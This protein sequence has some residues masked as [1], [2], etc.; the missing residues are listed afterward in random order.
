M[1]VFLSF[2]LKVYFCLGAH[3]QQ[4]TFA[5]YWSYW[6]SP[7]GLA[8]TSRIVLLPVLVTRGRS[9]RKCKK[10]F[11]VPPLCVVFFFFFFFP[12]LFFPSFLCT[13]KISLWI[14][15]FWSLFKDFNYCVKSVAGQFLKTLGFVC[16]SR[17]F[18][19][20]GFLLFVEDKLALDILLLNK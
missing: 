3:F 1:W 14:E 9:K 17:C 11:L 16:M 4:S 18:I 2:N 13:W 12:L 20:S 19:V 6:G 7:E 5:S 10:L 8:V 15:T